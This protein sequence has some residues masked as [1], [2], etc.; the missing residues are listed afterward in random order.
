M[1]IHSFL[2]FC[3]RRG[4]VFGCSNDGTPIHAL[5]EQSSLNIAL[6]ALKHFVSGITSPQ[7]PPASITVTE[8]LVHSHSCF[9]QLHLLKTQL[10]LLFLL[11]WANTHCLQELS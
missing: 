5:P 11:A 2:L 4:P 3:L 6:N 1:I 10:Q 9:P 7:G 8:P